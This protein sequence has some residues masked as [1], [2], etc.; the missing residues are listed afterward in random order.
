MCGL[1]YA[2]KNASVMIDMYATDSFNRISLL[3]P[4]NE[5]Y[6]RTQY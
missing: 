2:M 6:A 1:E 5:G 4:T 3:R